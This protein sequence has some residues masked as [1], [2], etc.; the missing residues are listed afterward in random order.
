[1]SK[2]YYDLL[3]LNKNATTEEI[4]KGYKKLAL[5]YHPDRNTENK[6]QNEIKFKEI[7]EAYN[8]L[9]DE[10]KRKDYDYFG[11]TENNT[12]DSTINID[13]LNDILSNMFNFNDANLDDILNGSNINPKVFVNMNEIPINTFNT[14]SD[15]FNNITNMMDDI[16][17]NTTKF[18]KTSSTQS[19]NYHNTTDN[20]KQH[21]KEYDLL[22]LKVNLDDIM[23]CKK[24]N[25]KYDIKDICNYCNGSCAVEPTDLIQCLYCKG[26]NNNCTSCNGSGNIFK[27]NRRCSYCNEGL[28]K[29]NM[30][31]NIAIPKSV[32]NNHIFII[33]NKGSYNKKTNSYNDIKLK[34]VYNL[35]KNIKI[36]ENNIIVKVDIKLSELFCGFKKSIKISNNI[37]E[38][39]MDKY[40]NPSE[41]IIYKN[42]GL[43]N[44][45]SHN[46]DNKD[47][48]D[49]IGDLILNFNVIYP[50]SDNKTIH[51]YKDVF[52]KIFSKDKEIN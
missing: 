14:N 51:K 36:K 31:I 16:L 24:K 37:I 21:N 29:K 6:E 12:F 9:S 38:I 3:E 52:I 8:V 13:P 46:K 15:M 40:F 42:K 2:N 35:E 5:K 47:N 39:S 1:M 4:K 26:T 50:K 34:I 32:P 49:N 45:K 25:I 43:V 28:I 18:N 10:K 22:D 11:L 17:F 30:E 7:T 44:Y 23:N 48:K 20:K 33:K 41:P 19:N 27:T